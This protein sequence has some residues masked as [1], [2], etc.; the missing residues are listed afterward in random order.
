V[1]DGVHIYFHFNV[2]VGIGD[3]VIQAVSRQ[4]TNTFAGTRF[5]TEAGKKYTRF[6]KIA[7]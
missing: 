1:S 4:R 5:C 7:D 3:A 2:I 6:R